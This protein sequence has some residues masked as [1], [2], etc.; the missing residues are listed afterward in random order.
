MMDEPI[1]TERNVNGYSVCVNEQLGHLWV[2]HDGH[3]TWEELQEIK[4]EVWG[5]EARAIEL[6]PA[7]RAVVNNASIRHLW[8]LGAADFAPDLLGHNS[9]LDEQPWGAA[10]LL[11]NRSRKAW[12]DA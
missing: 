5:A 10:D 3:I 7:D 12:K 4:S 2:E 8:R 9:S 1:I 6:Y 11:E